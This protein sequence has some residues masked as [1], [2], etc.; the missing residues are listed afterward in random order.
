MNYLKSDVE[1]M[2]SYSNNKSYLGENDNVYNQNPDMNNQDYEVQVNPIG[3]VK[4][5]SHQP[6]I[7]PKVINESKVK[8]G[9][10]SKE[11]KKPLSQVPSVQTTSS[12]KTV[13][14]PSKKK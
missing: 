6:T 14:P 7:Q 12:K 5:V 4:V 9:S 10:E 11:K 1:S 8:A 3:K 13:I 2:I